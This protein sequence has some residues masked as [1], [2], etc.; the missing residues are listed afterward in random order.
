MRKERKRAASA[1][2]AVNAAF[3]LKPTYQ[4]LVS[5]IEHFCLNEV[6]GNISPSY[7]CDFGGSFKDLP[8]SAIHSGVASGKAQH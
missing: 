7:L 8:Q 6:F 5:V 3:S 1:L 2:A 4:T